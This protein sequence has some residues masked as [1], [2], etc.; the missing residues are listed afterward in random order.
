MIR[1]TVTLS[2]NDVMAIS[3]NL[4]K[5]GIGG[6]TVTKERGRGKT[7]PPEVHA[8]KGRAVFTPQFSEK[9][10]ITAFVSEENEDRVVEIIKKNSR[11]GKIMIEPVLRAVD[12]ATGKEGDGII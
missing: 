1:I 6:L 7:P 4:K 10:I 9:Y 8:G 3:E 5:I 12:I 11:R 2:F